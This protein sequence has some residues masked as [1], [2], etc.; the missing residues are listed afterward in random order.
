M[1]LIQKE[2][3]EGYS[4]GADGDDDKLYHTA[5]LPFG[6]LGFG[7]NIEDILGYDIDALFRMD[8]VA[9]AGENVV[10]TVL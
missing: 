7:F 6:S 5:F 2:I 9:V 1:K 4:Y 10:L 8:F 3:G